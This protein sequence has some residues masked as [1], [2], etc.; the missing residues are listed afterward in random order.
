MKLF[1]KT[2]GN[3]IPN[4]LSPVGIAKF[5]VLPVRT[6]RNPFNEQKWSRVYIPT[7]N[8]L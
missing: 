2:V 1:I 5:L 8:I 6:Y 3:F 7:Q 4:K